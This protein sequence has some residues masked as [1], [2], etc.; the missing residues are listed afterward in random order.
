MKRTVFTLFMLGIFSIS[1]AQIP[2]SQRMV[3]LEEGTGASCPYCAQYNPALNALIDANPTKVIAIKYQEYTPD[4]MSTPDGV[5][6]MG[7]SFY[8]CTGYPHVYLDGLYWNDHPASLTQGIIDTRYAISSPFTIAISHSFSLD[9]DSIFISMTIT[10][11][12]PV[13]L[14]GPVKAHVVINE[15]WIHFATAPGS[16]GETDFFDVLRKMLPD[17]NGTAMATSWTT[18]QTQTITLNRPVPTN[19]YSISQVGVVGF[20]QDNSNKYI[21]QAGY[22]A[23]LPQPLDAGITGVTGVPTMQCNLNPFTTTATLKNFGTTTL[24][25]CTINYKIDG[26]A[27]QTQAWTGSLAQNATTTVTLPSITPT[28]GGHTLAVYTTLPNGSTDGNAMNDQATAAYTALGAVMTPPVTQ[29][30]TSTTFPPT[31]WVKIDV[32][33]DAKNWARLT[34]GHTAAGSAYINWYNISSGQID[35]MMTNPIDLSTATTATLTFW[36]AYRQYS[37]ENDKLQ[38]DVSNNCGSSWTNKWQ[39][40]G[41]TLK[42]GAAVT[43]NWTAPTAAEWRQETVDFASVVGQ[44][45]VLAR[46]RATSAYGNNCFVDDINLTVTTSIDEN[47]SLISNYTVYPN[48]FSNATT[49]NFTLAKQDE[50]RVSVYNEQGQLVFNQAQTLPA[51]SHVMPINAQ[52]WASGL[53][54]ITVTT[55]EKSVSKKVV[56]NK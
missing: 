31:N 42:T 24:T 19:V 40:S 33:G 17:Y 34:A 32:G 25:S 23:A 1:F 8:N 20:I 6:R 30:F 39:K 55:S 37:S 41:A 5:Y 4:P 10:A 36:V 9:L 29:D 15:E 16:N 27:A 22:S 46:F 3:L 38:V 18:G 14:T 56:L 13:T 21:I 11:T 12:E 50:I 48:P 7:S 54:Q 44:S 43:S 26:G 2:K 49:L 52:D 35:D 53:Y 28:T 47:T 45:G 51:G